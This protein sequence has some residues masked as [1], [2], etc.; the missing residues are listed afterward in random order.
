MCRSLHPCGDVSVSNLTSLSVGDASA[1]VHLSSCILSFIFFSFFLSLSL[2][3]VLSFFL[4]SLSRALI[5]FFLSGGDGF[6][7]DGFIC[8]DALHVWGILEFL[9][10]PQIQPMENRLFHAK[11]FSFQG[12]EKQRNKKKQ[13]MKKVFISRS[14][15]LARI[16]TTILRLLCSSPSLFRWMSFFFF[17]SSS[18]SSF[19]LFFFVSLKICIDISTEVYR[20]TQIQI[21]RA[22]ACR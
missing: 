7:C 20:E 1:F 5:R 13:R 17:S 8:L 22:A 2:S 19:L 15:A 21:N 6:V 14:P 4:S 16:V 11:T 12:K 3:L 18:S 9:S 10:R